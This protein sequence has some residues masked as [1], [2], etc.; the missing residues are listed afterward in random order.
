MKEDLAHWVQFTKVLDVHNQC[1]I[2]EKGLFMKASGV[3]VQAAAVIQAKAK[4]KAKQLPGV[5]PQPAPLATYVVSKK[6]K[7]RGR[8]NRGRIPSR[9]S[10]PKLPLPP[11][12][13]IQKL[14]VAAPAAT[15]ALAAAEHGPSPV[16][17][18]RVVLDAKVDRKSSLGAGG[19]S[20]KEDTS[21]VS[22]PQFL[23]LDFHL[24]QDQSSSKSGS[25]HRPDLKATRDRAK[26]HQPP[27][28]RPQGLG[29]CQGRGHCQDHTPNP[30]RGGRRTL[31]SS[32]LPGGTQGTGTRRGR[33]VQLVHRELSSHAEI[34]Q[35]S[36]TLKF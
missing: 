20:T 8:T 31:A 34:A 9:D 13:R 16:M 5:G 18:A 3:Q 10:D 1:L 11:S 19:S 6:K 15:M 35:L 12:L 30:V 28:K 7:A 33:F 14:A 36:L 4:A 21:A 26:V 24:K 25:D 27:R 2:L 32:L 17:D 22:P 29:P 23:A